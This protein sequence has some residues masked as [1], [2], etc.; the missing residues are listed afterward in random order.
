MADFK[1]DFSAANSRFFKKAPFLGAFFDIFL[2]NHCLICD[3][4]ISSERIICSNCISEIESINPSPFREKIGK[5][6]YLYYY[7]YYEGM[8]SKLILK[9][10]Y[11]NHRFLSR[12]LAYMVYILI[13]S[14]NIKG[15]IIT[16]IPSH[17]LSDKKRGFSNTGRI[18]KDLQMSYLNYY[19]ISGLFI[20][21]GKYVPQ[22]SLNDP[23]KRKIN[24]ENSYFLRNER[25][26]QPHDGGV[27]VFD[28][29]YTTGHTMKRAVGLLD[30]KFKYINCIVIAKRKG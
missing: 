29:V 10:K 2:P 5:D 17:T 24:A 27:L 9:Y 26:L 22:A 12:I 28:D 4:I 14:W 1:I 19:N 25:N 15:D 21:K 18:I 13:S 8:L 6:I 3:K 11:G 7:G 30:K 23:E 20:R 16:G